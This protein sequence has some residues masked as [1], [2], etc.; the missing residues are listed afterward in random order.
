[1]DQDIQKQRQEDQQEDNGRLPSPSQGCSRFARSSESSSIHEWLERKEKGSVKPKRK[2]ITRS[3]RLGKKQSLKP[4]SEKQK[5]KNSSYA[6]AKAKFYAKEENRSCFLCGGV[7][8]LSIHH[9]SKRGNLIDDLN[10]FVTLCLVGNFMDLKYLESNHSHQGGC[11]SWV[12]ANK[13]IAR[14]LKL[15]L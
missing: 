11:H 8:H 5:K 2:A 4:I 10:T 15:I 3:K 13:S 6:S 12:E 14:E 1:M 9:K 7:N